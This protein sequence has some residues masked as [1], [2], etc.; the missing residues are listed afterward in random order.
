MPG[1]WSSNRCVLLIWALIFLV[2]AP[3]MHLPVSQAGDEIATD[4]GE[5][6]KQREAYQSQYNL[7]KAVQKRLDVYGYRPGPID[8]IF[9]PKTRAALMAFQK[10]KELNADGLIG[11]ETLRK[12]GLIRKSN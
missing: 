3:L 5:M 10:D 4:N 6:A 8:G 11:I 7:V 9:G 1:R 12:L 2:T